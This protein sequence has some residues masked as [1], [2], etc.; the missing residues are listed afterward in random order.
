MSSIA[1]NLCEEVLQLLRQ[2]PEAGPFLEPV[3]WKKYNVPDY[4]RIVKHPMDLGTVANK[5]SSNEYGTC[6]EF[7]EDVRLVWRNAMLFNRSGSAIYNAAEKLS[8][9][10]E[11]KY[12][13]VVT[14]VQ[15]S[16]KQRQQSTHE[17]TKE[18]RLKFSQL[19]R[20]LDS[21][22]LARVI[23]V[24]EQRCPQALREDNAEAI[25]IEV[26][27]IDAVVLLKLNESMEV[28]LEIDKA[29]K[30]GQ[31]AQSA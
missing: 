29:A 5:L 1:F 18:D 11:R 3:D 26:F 6:K 13:Q 12:Q 9:L 2:H 27:A 15:N 23:D 22:A 17:A 14:K 8:K 30:Q 21:T 20:Q 10:F 31:H 4:P 19:I 24:I 25:E 28:H 16:M 7:A